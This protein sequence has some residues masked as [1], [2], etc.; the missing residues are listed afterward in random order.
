M[1]MARL[2]TDN[3]GVDQPDRELLGSNGVFGNQNASGHHVRRETES[4]I[5]IKAEESA[6][7]CSWY[8]VSQYLDEHRQEVLI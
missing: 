8:N 5:S 1:K 6:V 3:V 7:E 2:T 4:N